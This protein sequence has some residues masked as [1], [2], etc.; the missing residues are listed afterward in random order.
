M[1]TMTTIFLLLFSICLFLYF[2][3]EILSVD[4]IILDM[5]RNLVLVFGGICLL[6]TS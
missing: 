5:V 6:L 4:K 2:V 1:I 3:L